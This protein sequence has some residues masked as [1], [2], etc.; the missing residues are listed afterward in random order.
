M[1]S[2]VELKGTI[3]RL[4][5]ALGEADG[6]EEP[7][8]EALTVR[9]TLGETLPLAV[10]L[11]VALT[12]GETLPLAVVLRV[13][14]GVVDDVRVTLGETLADAEGDAEGEGGGGA[15]M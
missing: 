6:L 15:L 10:V 3:E 13:T 14:L 8:E 11:S 1:E 9:L 7:E 4:G 2:T 12:L 5:L